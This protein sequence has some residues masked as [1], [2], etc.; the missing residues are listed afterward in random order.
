MDCKTCNHT[1]TSGNADTA[2]YRSII[3]RRNTE[4]ILLFVL[5]ILLAVAFTGYAVYVKWVD[6]QF[7]TVSEDIRVISEDNGD[8]NY[9]GNDGDIIY[10]EDTR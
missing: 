1:A 7:E 6:S 2:F 4:C 5:C 3:K 8:A 10:G 9:I